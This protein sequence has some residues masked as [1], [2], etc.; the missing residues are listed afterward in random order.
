[1]YLCGQ[2]QVKDKKNATSMI[3]QTPAALHLIIYK[4]R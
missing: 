2:A 1:V 4:P 3:G